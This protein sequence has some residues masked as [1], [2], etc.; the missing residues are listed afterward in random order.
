MLQKGLVGIMKELENKNA[1]HLPDE[2][3][4]DYTKSDKEN[5]KS[6]DSYSKASRRAWEDLK[7]DKHKN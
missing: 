1:V 2:W 5:E 7:Q 6:L 3:A 4:H